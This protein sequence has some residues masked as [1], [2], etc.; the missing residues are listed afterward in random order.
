MQPTPAA[1]MPPHNRHALG[2]VMTAIDPDQKILVVELPR[3][4]GTVVSFAN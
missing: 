3:D 1:H 2:K 4:C